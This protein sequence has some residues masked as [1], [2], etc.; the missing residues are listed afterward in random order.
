LITRSIGRNEWIKHTNHSTDR[1]WRECRVRVVESVGGCFE[2]NIA[3]SDKKKEIEQV[4]EE[5]A[6]V[7]K[8]KGFYKLLVIA[9][10]SFIVPLILAVNDAA[11]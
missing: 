4:R 11:N 3:D 1:K 2:I 7:Q 10:M 6:Y 5:E 8:V 9:V